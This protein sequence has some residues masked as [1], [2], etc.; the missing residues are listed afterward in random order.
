M[1]SP[2]KYIAGGNSWSGVSKWEAVNWEEKYQRLVRNVPD[3]I[4]LV[5]PDC[6]I[7]SLNP[8]FEAITGWSR[9][10]WLGKSIRNLIDPEDVS[11]VLAALSS[12][13]RGEEVPLFEAR[14]RHKSGRT[15]LIECSI[16]PE[17]TDAG[18]IA[19]LGIARD[20]TRRRETE[21]TLHRTQSQLLH[22]QKM[23]AVGRLAGGVAHDFN[24]MLTVILGC[25]HLLLNG[26]SVGNAHRDLVR[27]IIS[28]GERAAGLTRQLLAFS[29]KDAPHPKI[30]DL[31]LVVTNLKEMLRRLLGTQVEIQTCLEPKIGRVK[32]DAGQIEQVIVNL[33]INSRDAMPTGGTI[34]IRTANV[35]FD[36]REP[37]ICPELPPG[38]YV[39]LTL[40]DN[41]LGMDPETKDHL[42]EP[43]FTTK[44]LG[45]GTGLGLA[46]AYGIVR[47]AHGAIRIESER[48]HGTAV[49]IYLPQT[50]EE[51]ALETNSQKTQAPESAAGTVL[52]VEDED[53]VRA[54]ARH[55][56]RS[57]GYR[58]LEAVR[59]EEAVRL[60]ER[61]AGP[62][63][64]LLSD[65]VMP[66][67]TG[68]E[69][70]DRLSA[71]RPNYEW[72][73]C[74]GTPMMI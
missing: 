73:S 5:A 67:I 20:I 41:G 66:P 22:A 57:A 9:R 1:L 69:L 12:S 72:C 26:S 62:I 64:L 71:L 50:R 25:G 30:V 44:E 37:Q 4:F 47:Q 53:S 70:A 60:C 63:H 11:R 16:T 34:A 59:G 8:T 55:V 74:P 48:G 19:V 61:H 45:K 13:A 21:E 24:N 23:D 49:T 35:V 58:V 33:A 10:D 54:L 27:E 46:T 38:P 52:I 7:I 36:G 15:R 51:I 56:L 42:F 28:A 18:V 6:T 65:V 29:R 3:G 43:F 2:S 40:T 31:N 17:V 32:I 14:I 68:T 39:A